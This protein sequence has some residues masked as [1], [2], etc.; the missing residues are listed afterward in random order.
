MERTAK[1]RLKWKC[2][3]GLLELDLVFERF[4]PTL[5]DEEA[6][7]FAS[8]LELPDN[9]LWDIV[10]GRCDDFPPRCS[11]IVARLRAA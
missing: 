2:R 3:R 10:A 8:L 6:D 1:E 11:E 4:V 7:S 9:R 5:R